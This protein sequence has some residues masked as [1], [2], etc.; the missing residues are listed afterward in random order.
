VGKEHDVFVI[1]TAVPAFR[2]VTLPGKVFLGIAWT[3]AGSYVNAERA[4]LDHQDRVRF[5]TQK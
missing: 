5:M 1:H 4:L 3:I 2:S